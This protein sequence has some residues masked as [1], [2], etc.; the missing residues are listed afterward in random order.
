MLRLST[1]ART[2]APSVFS[3]RR[4]QAVMMS[5]ERGSGTR[6]RSGIGSM[7]APGLE[8]VRQHDRHGERIR[9]TMRRNRDRGVDQ[10][11]GGRAPARV[12]RRVES[13]IE[14]PSST[15]LASAM[16]R[17]RRRAPAGKARRG[18]PMT[19][20]RCIRRQA[21][22]RAPELMKPIRPSSPTGDGDHVR[23]MRKE[24]PW[25]RRYER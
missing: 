13:R 21:N 24:T 3:P 12:A 6:D 18:A 2:I 17:R 25:R 15:M 23:I 16:R 5:A 14:Q 8:I 7:S 4:T 20:R 22:T 10:P 9:R 1:A 11:D 19:S